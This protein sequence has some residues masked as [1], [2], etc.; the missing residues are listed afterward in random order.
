MTDS[1]RPGILGTTGSFGSI[2]ITDGQDG[3]TQKQILDKDRNLQEIQNIN[4]SG[5]LTADGNASIAGDVTITGDLTINGATTTVST[6]NL[7]V[8][9]NLILLNSG[10]G[11]DE[12][13]TGLLFDRGTL[14]DNAFMGWDESEDKFILGTT[15]ATSTDT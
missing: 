9:D 6:T 1:W 5:N 2:Q 10:S 8:E 4:L 15:T 11:D 3:G 7:D 14:G 13:D 12:N